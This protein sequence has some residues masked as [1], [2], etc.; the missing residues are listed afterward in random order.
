[1]TSVPKTVG[2]TAD[3]CRAG[4]ALVGMS[5]PALAEVAEVGLSTVLNFEKGH[6]TPRPKNLVD[7]I[8]ALEAAGVIFLDAAEGRGPGVAVALRLKRKRDE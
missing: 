7:M 6:A 8:A 5:Q 3:Q 2:M 1:M 4:R